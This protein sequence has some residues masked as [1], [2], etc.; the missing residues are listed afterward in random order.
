MLKRYMPTSLLKRSFLI[1]VLPVIIMQT[2]VVYSF[3]Q[4]HWR[5]VNTRLTESVAGD[6]ALAMTLYREQSDPQDL[7][8]IRDHFMIMKNISIAFHE[9][10]ELPKTKRLSLFSEFDQALRRALGRQITT[11]FWFDTTRYPAY[12]DIRLK[13]DH[14]VLRF[15]AQRDRVFANTG[16]IFLLWIAMVTLLL[17]GVSL[18]FIRNQVRPIQNLAYAAEAFGKGQDVAYFKPAGARE[19]RLAA[20]AFVEMRQRLKRYLEQRTALLASVSHDIRTPLARLKLHFAMTPDTEENRAA[21]QDLHDME[22]MLD[23]YLAF[24]QGEDG[25]KARDS[26]LIS[27]IKEAVKK[28]HNGGKNVVNKLKGS[29]IATVRPQALRRAL[30]NLIDNAILYG[31]K[32]FITCKE[33]DTHF[34]I[35]IDDQGPGIPPEKR[36]EAFKAFHRLDKSRNQNTKG[37]GLGLAIAQDIARRHGG[38]ILLEESPRGGLRSILSLPK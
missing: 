1:I 11:P 19:V 3:F 12:I 33:T 2:A 14:G 20:R 6:I 31:K 30:I 13:T 21:R 7:E 32:A 15:I 35:I 36:K 37:V 17:T 10:E 16:Y 38:E 9:G 18:L 22:N 8:K 28:S 29:R 25:E 34:Q 24:A 4:E 27:L 5:T 23:E 26:D